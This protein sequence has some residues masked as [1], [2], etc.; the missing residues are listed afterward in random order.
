MTA[1]ITD[2]KTADTR[3]PLD[4]LLLNDPRKA[5]RAA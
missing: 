4:T 3:E 2:V 5:R 1:R